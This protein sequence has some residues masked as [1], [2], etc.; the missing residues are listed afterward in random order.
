MHQFAG[1]HSP[2]PP[3]FS[4]CRCV[5]LNVPG[6]FSVSIH[7]NIQAA[8][9]ASS[10]GTEPSWAAGG[11]LPSRRKSCSSVSFEHVLGSST[12]RLIVGEDS[13]LESVGTGESNGQPQPDPCSSVPVASCRSAL[14]KS[15]VFCFHSANFASAKYGSHL[16]GLSV[17]PLLGRATS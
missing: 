17:S 14:A 10:F 7:L 8:G 6:R 13:I 4:F 15:A 2:F 16:I 3:L 11:S 9:S 1:P 12:E 5:F